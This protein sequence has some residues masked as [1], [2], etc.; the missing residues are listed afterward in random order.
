MSN[1]KKLLIGVSGSIAA[2]KV[3]H[4]ISHFRKKNWEV[5]IIT[6]PSALQ[7]IGAA[8]L[9]GLSE[10]EVLSS[11]FVSGR[12]MS[13]IE[14][15]RWA[16]VFLIA[17]ATA[18]TINSLATGTGEGILNSTYLAY[19]CA[20][21]LLIAPAMNTQM[22]AHPT[23]QTALQT[24]KKNGVHILETNSGQL[25]CGEVGDGRMMEPEHIAVAIERSLAPKNA[26]THVLITMG[27]TRVPID[28]VR[29][30]TN[31]SSGETGAQL[32][33]DLYLRGYD[34]TVLAARNAIKPKLTTSIKTFDTYDD[35]EKLLEKTLTENRFNHIIHMAAV[36]DFTV[37]ANT[38]KI[39]SGKN[40]NL[41]LIPTK[42]LITMIKTW[43]PQAFVTGF[44]LT[45]NAPRGDVDNAV[46]SVIRNGANAV[47]HNELSQIT[48][49]SHVF[50]LY[51][52]QGPIAKVDLKTDLVSLFT[53][54]LFAADF[55]F[56]SHAQNSNEVPYDS[57]S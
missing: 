55:P 43:A 22:L 50:T 32:A 38:Q 8:T 16:D 25:A 40:I 3:A 36:S 6:T 51:S 24:L 21:P 4:V 39:S 42:K 52:Y 35:L 54:T 29:S 49:N 11:D 23:T 53:N 37:P 10:N 48:K 33:D 2:F 19:D 14:L 5:R 46:K 18:K 9:E 27:G 13:H 26:S 20:K 7:F 31:T 45:V 15:A 12:M 44:K 57:M 17:P 41:E 56:G 47:I 30:I 34:V 1:S 28:G